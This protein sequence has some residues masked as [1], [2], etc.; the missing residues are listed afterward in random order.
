MK[1][2]LSFS[3]YSA[4]LSCCIR[5]Q[6]EQQH[7]QRQSVHPTVATW[8]ESFELQVKSCGCKRTV[9]FEAILLPDLAAL[10]H[11]KDPLAAKVGQGVP[12]TAVAIE[13]GPAIK[14]GIFMNAVGDTTVGYAWQ[15][16]CNRVRTRSA[17]STLGVGT[18]SMSKGR[19]RME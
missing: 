17:R 15:D 10:V 12:A 3:R 14:L 18:Y 9:A 19:R 11:L 1:P 5:S 2:V 13:H 16:C 8:S 4:S 7:A 6:S